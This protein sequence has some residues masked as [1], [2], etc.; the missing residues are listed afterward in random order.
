MPRLEIDEF[1]GFSYNDVKKKLEE[2]GFDFTKPITRWED[3]EQ[4]KI[5]YKQE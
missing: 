4:G 3:K 1:E 2:A 5:I